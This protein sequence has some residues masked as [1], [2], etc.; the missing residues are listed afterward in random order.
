MI[1]NIKV[2]KNYYKQ[3]PES[4]N[5]VKTYNYNYTAAVTVSLAT[6]SLFLIFKPRSK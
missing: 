6:M 2:S 4:D 3:F 5:I 1:K